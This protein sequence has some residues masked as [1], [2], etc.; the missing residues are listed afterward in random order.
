VLRNIPGDNDNELSRY[1]TRRPYR[2]KGRHQMM[3]P[4]LF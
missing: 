2:L 4:F 3:P 1:N